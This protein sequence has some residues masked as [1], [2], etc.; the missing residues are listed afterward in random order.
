MPNGR[1]A[2][3]LQVLCRQVRQDTLG[4]DGD[5]VPRGGGSA[6]ACV[7]LARRW[8]LIVVAPAFSATALTRPLLPLHRRR[9]QVRAPAMQRA[10]CALR[11]V[12]R[13]PS[14]AC[15]APLRDDAPFRRGFDRPR[16][17]PADP[18]VSAASA[19]LLELP[20]VVRRAAPLV[21]RLD[22]TVPRLR[23]DCA[24]LAALRS[25]RRSRPASHA[26][27]AA[28]LRHAAPAAN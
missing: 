6:L 7:G 14:S 11:R 22:E 4:S 15:V 20:D 28:V 8:H 17:P 21:V 3:V 27:A 26:R 12:R 1:D 23:D 25:L 16:Q 18:V 19:A 24:E 2:E 10:A 9:S 5:E 13:L